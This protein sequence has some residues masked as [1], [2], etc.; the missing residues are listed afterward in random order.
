MSGKIPINKSTELLNLL[1]ELFIKLQSEFKTVYKGRVTIS[2]TDASNDIINIAEENFEKIKDH[3]SGVKADYINSIK[4]ECNTNPKN[5]ESV[6]LSFS[7]GTLRGIHKAYKKTGKSRAIGKKVANVFALYLGYYGWNGFIDGTRIEDEEAIK[8]KHETTLNESKQPYQVSNNAESKSKDNK[9]TDSVISIRNKT[10]RLVTYVFLSITCILLLCYFLISYFQTKDRFPDGVNGILV[11][12][13]ERDSL[14]NLRSDLVE[15]LNTRMDTSLK[16]DARIFNAKINLEK[17]ESDAHNQARKIGR[18]QNAKLVIWGDYI[19]N[20]EKLY[21]FIT[22]IDNA[23]LKNFVD[24]EVEMDALFVGD[25]ELPPIIVS[26]PETILT[27]I[28]GKLA[29]QNNDYL[30]ALEY[31]KK[32]ENQDK[33]KEINHENLLI[34]IGVCYAFQALR[35]NRT[36]N[37]GKAEEYFVKTI[38]LYPNTRDGHNNLV[39]IY[40]LNKEFNKCLEHSNYI[41]DNNLTSSATWSHFGSL[42]YYL[43]SLDKAIE[44]FELSLLE[45]PG[46]YHS[47]SMIG[48][49]FKRKGNCN[50][51]IDYFNKAIKLNENDISALYEKGMCYYLNEEYDDAISSLKITVEKAPNHLKA[52]LALSNIY[53]KTDMSKAIRYWKKVV[54]TVPPAFGLSY[55]LGNLYDQV[56]ENDSAIKYY[57]IAIS[58]NSKRYEPWVSLGLMYSNNGNYNQAVKHLSQAVKLNDTLYLIWYK[59]GICH[60]NLGDYKKAHNSQLKALSINSDY[61][62]AW[63]EKGRTFFKQS[64]YRNAVIDFKTAIRLNP[65]NYEPHYLMGISKLNLNLGTEALES[66]YTAKLLIDQ[67]STKKLTDIWLRIGNAYLTLEDYKRSE[68]AYIEALDIDAEF[69]Q[70]KFCLGIVRSMVNDKSS[71]FKYFDEAEKLR[72]NDIQVLLY[73]GL[74]YINLNIPNEAQ[75]CFDQINLNP[76]GKIIGNVGLGFLSLTNNNWNDAPQ[77]FNEASIVFDTEA[78]YFSYIQEVAK[79]IK[80]GLLEEGWFDKLNEL[81]E[82]KLRQ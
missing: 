62:S 38:S 18:K 65:N 20:K 46:D 50:K 10:R 14:G 19:S 54:N 67:D 58:L 48:S 40:L 64:R 29:L 63:L 66:F 49:C 60:F 35:E 17:G 42:Y 81:L 23:P 15:T 52:W 71:A 2:F 13:I 3:K 77:Y 21:P 47:Y 51:A 9:E 6:N 11:L 75:I 45:N 34:Q 8:S 41:V 37:R 22:I 36:E 69:I 4:K 74:G 33:V 5:P 44:Y 43:D 31:F 25:F 7:E 26:K 80:P 59:L 78:E 53:K 56:N 79:F 76:G 1:Q 32:I 55:M 73:K 39:M 57:N 61:F 24:T 30:K 28:K 72:T 27:F 16:I 70:T 12:T 82:L 68:E